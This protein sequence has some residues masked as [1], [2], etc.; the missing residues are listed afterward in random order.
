MSQAVLQQ[1][2]A[3]L[4]ADSLIRAM[5]TWMNRVEPGRGVLLEADSMIRAMWTRAAGDGAVLARLRRGQEMARM[6]K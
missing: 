6:A 1:S 2:G 4:E 5:W 3:A